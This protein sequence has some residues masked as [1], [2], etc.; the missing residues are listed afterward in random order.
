MSHYRIM[1]RGVVKG[2]SVDEVVQ[3]LARFSKKPPEALRTLLTSGRDVVAKRVAEVQHAV[4]YKQALENLGCVCVIQAEITAPSDAPAS[5]G[6]TSV[7]V[8]SFTTGQAS[9]QASAREYQYAS[10][11]LAVRMR[12]MTAWLGVVAM[13]A[14]AYYGW[15]SFY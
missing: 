14:V 2:R 6:S 7:L 9:V 11:P 1:L 10:P 15:K 4:K 13:L 3:S 8:T 5:E 12:G